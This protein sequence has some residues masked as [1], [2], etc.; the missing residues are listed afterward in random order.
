MLGVSLFLRREYIIG[1]IFITRPLLISLRLSQ[2]LPTEDALADPLASSISFRTAS[3]IYPAAMLSFFSLNPSKTELTKSPQP[4]KLHSCIRTWVPSQSANQGHCVILSRAAVRI[5]QSL[6][7][8]NFR[9]ILSTQVAPWCL[10][11]MKELRADFRSVV[12][13][14]YGIV[15]RAVVVAILLTCSQ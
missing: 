5:S 15:W 4:A 7:F 12:M 11:R 10:P 2:S 1:A 9:N 8:W 3:A 6:Q 13:G 14:T